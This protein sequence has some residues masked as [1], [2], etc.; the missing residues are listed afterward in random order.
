MDKVIKEDAPAGQPA[1]LSPLGHPQDRIFGLVSEGLVRN[2]A[3]LDKVASNFTEYGQAM[4][5]GGILYKDIRG[6]SWDKNSTP[7]GKIDD[8]DQT[9]LSNNGIPRINYGINLSA[10]WKG[11]SLSALFQGVAEYDRV[12]STSNGGGVFQTGDRP[13]FEIWAKNRWSS[14]NPNA[15]FPRA[16]AWGMPQFGWGTSTFWMRNGAYMRL[17]NLTVAYS[18]PQKLISPLKMKS[19][20]FYFNGTDLF[21]ISSV[22]IMDPEQA[23]LDSYPIMKSFTGGIT[24]T[25]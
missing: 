10:E 12:I 17:K 16:A 3:Q 25:F 11:I 6:E 18:L 5:L 9:W 19:C 24:V 1:W 4:M 14:D 20:Q 21:V 15:K 22:K 13:Y 2:Q 7:N 8:Y 23:L